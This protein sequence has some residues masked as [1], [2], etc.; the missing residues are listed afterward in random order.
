MSGIC[1]ILTFDGRPVSEEAVR[2]MMS[3]AP[4]RGPDGDSTWTGAGA[5]L[6][7]QSL[8]IGPDSTHEQQPFQQKGD[9]CV[10]V[11]DA[12]ID[13]RTELLRELG[14]QP[15]LNEA[16][17]D[18]ALILAAF[19]RWGADA[20]ARLVGD[21]A[22]AVWDRE[23]KRVV[24]ARDPMAMRPLYYRH[25]A[26]RLLFGSEVK[27]IL[28]SGDVPRRLD[29]A[30]V[31]AFLAGDFGPAGWTFYSG[32]QQLP[33]AHVLVADK[34][35]ARVTRYWDA[36]PS[37]QIR[38]P[39]E[40]QYAEHLLELLSE[41]VSARLRGTRPMGLFLSGGMDS[42]SIAATAGWLKTKQ[43]ADVAPLHT[44]SW[45]FPTLAECDERHIS[46][47]LVDHY[48]LLSSDIDAEAAA[49][50]SGYPRHGPDADDPYVGV[51]QPLLEATLA[52]ARDDGVRLM[53][54]GE[55]GDLS[56]GDYIY[57]YPGLFWRG[58]WRT[59]LEEL[60]MQAGWKNAS[61]AAMLNI[62]LLRP[63]RAHVWP[64]GRAEW[65]REPLRRTY[66]RFR[67]RPIS[68]PW[69]RPEFS[70]ATNLD[71]I[72]RQRPEQAD[73]QPLARHKRYQ[74][75]F[76][77]MHVRGMVWSDRTQARFGIGFADPWSDRRIAEF[78][79]AVPQRLL[80]RTGDNKRLVRRAM[81]GV[82]PEET[83]GAIRKITPYPLYM[84]SLKQR[85]Q[86]TVRELLTDMRAAA[87]GFVDEAGLRGHY[88]SICR[89][90]P[91]HP[92][93][94]WSLCVE[95]WLREHWE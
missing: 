70:A 8:Q 4:H 12:R 35:G 10:L 33:P 66:R 53:M 3:A 48:R 87:H 67:K 31:A 61:V 51:Y 65:A 82:M 64:P 11:A 86:A 60:R 9:G 57:D 83:L 22:F 5:G 7:Y 49:P 68:P 93:F 85:E 36:E 15:G 17:S 71:E 24:A 42:T 41:S 21:F 89:G 19:R 25:E 55:R 37:R 73:F 72:L 1:G 34:N 78:A 69:L 56:M 26:G 27:Q 6:G 14:G 18:A 32:I 45:A 91:E 2:R 58:Q 77:P 23:K 54:S 39:D 90:S 28:A 40:A 63:A 75:I 30:T 88:D 92:G 52:A 20:P 62:F 81:R 59:L 80:N 29:E 84:R 43:S 13:N 46:S 47:G 16:A 79:L 44:Y 76:T 74:A 94:W 50:L 38:Y 95:M